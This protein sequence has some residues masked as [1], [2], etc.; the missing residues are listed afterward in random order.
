L[1]KNEKKLSHMSNSTNSLSFFDWLIDWLI[2]FELFVI[3]RTYRLTCA[4]LCEILHELKFI[5]ERVRAVHSL[6][7]SLT[8]RH[9]NVHLILDKVR[10]PRELQILRSV[11]LPNDTA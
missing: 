1:F 9:Q 4:Q 3:F 8:D 11:L 2:D 7:N 5:D 10:F 6:C